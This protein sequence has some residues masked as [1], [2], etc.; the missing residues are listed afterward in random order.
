MRR[1]IS[2]SLFVA[3]VFL[4]A[5]FL[6]CVTQKAPLKVVNSLPHE[7]LAR[8]N[9]SFDTFKK[10]LWGKGGV[11]S[12]EEQLENF[13]FA[14]VQFKNGSLIIETETGM[15]SKGALASNYS[16]QGDFDI[17]LDCRMDFYEGLQEMDQFMSFIV[18]QK[19]VEISK[20]NSVQ[21]G[22]SKREGLTKGYL[23]CGYRKNGTFHRAKSIEI[24][25]FHGTF[26][27][28]RIG[29]KVTVLYR[30]KEKSGW[31][32]LA[33]V[34]FFAAQVYLSFRV[35]NFIGNK[36]SIR[37]PMPVKAAFDNFKINAAQEII[38][39]EI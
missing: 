2:S 25:S 14:G 37:A 28:V 39:S 6:G 8:Y 36:K 16:I 30:R 20:M 4:F 35:Q 31:K 11:L 15:L 18:F 32:R 7:R 19:G 10:D 5:L 34:P 17:Q 26:R 33:Q 9:D 13:K 27:L 12:S 1:Y 24:K 21:V 22:L 29:D 3:L 38:E 23:Y